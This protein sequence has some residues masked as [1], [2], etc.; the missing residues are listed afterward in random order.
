ME[1]EQTI[2]AE[3]Q[4]LL[5]SA[6]IAKSIQYINYKPHP[7]IT[8]T[9][10]VGWAAD[11]HAGMLGK[12]ATYSYEKAHRGYSCEHPGCTASFDEHKY[13][14]ILFLQLT[15][16]VS[17]EEGHGSLYKLSDLLAQNGIDGILF[18]ETPKKYR[19]GS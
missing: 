4:Q 6:F 15:R 9:K 8:G 7:F 10:L 13:D 14:T 16:D 19:I 2:L 1:N 18:V 3:A 17:A 12:E 5:G 11:N